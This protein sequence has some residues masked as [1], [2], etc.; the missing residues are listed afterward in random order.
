VQAPELILQ[1]ADVLGGNVIGLVRVISTAQSSLH[2]ATKIASCDL[3]FAVPVDDAMRRLGSRRVRQ[4]GDHLRIATHSHDHLVI[5]CAHK[6]HWDVRPIFGPELPD[7]Q[8][9]ALIVRSG[10]VAES[11]A[12]RARS[13][14]VSTS[15][16]NKCRTRQPRVGIRMGDLGLTAKWGLLRLQRPRVHLR[17][18]CDHQTG[19]PPDTMPTGRKELHAELYGNRQ[20]V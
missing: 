7:I 1:F 12:G 16:T 17:L 20:H 18:A 15:M 2:S 14:S 9:L 8:D 3:A 4:L 11:E 10:A 6:I 13:T 19:C 5:Q